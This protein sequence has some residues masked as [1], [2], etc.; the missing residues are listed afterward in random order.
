MR[1][2]NRERIVE[3]LQKFGDITQDDAAT[4]IVPKIY[5]LSQEITRLEQAGYV[6][7]HIRESNAY[8]HWTR[9]K[10]VNVPFK[11]ELVG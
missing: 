1:K 10:L 5:S 7:E 8:T 3:Y 4:K 9:Y 6:F 2:N 11:L